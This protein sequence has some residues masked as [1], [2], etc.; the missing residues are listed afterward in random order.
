LLLASNHQPALFRGGVEG[1][2]HP[3]QVPW[4]IKAPAT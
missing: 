4:I 3:Q 2:L 1:H